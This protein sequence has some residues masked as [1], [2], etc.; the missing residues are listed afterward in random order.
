MLWR[1]M[2]EDKLATV[3]YVMDGC[4]SMLRYP[5]VALDLGRWVGIECDRVKGDFWPWISDPAVRIAP[6][7]IMCVRLIWTDETRSNGPDCII[8]LRLGKFA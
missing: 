2:V 1:G 6:R 7:F 3:G 8:P 4:D 5:F